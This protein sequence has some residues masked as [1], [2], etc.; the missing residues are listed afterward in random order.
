PTLV[1]KPQG[2][3]EGFIWKQVS[4][5]WFHSAAIGSDGNL[6]TWGWNANGK[7]GDGTTTDRHTPTL[8]EK[9]TGAP[10]G[11][12][13]KQVILGD[14]HTAA[15]G[16][17]GN[18]YIWGF[19]GNSRL[20]DGTTTDRHTPT[21]V[22]KPQGTPDGFT[23]KQISLGGWH[24]AAIGSDGNLY[25]W[26]YSGD[27]ELGRDISASIPGRPGKID[28][29]TGAPDGF[30]W[31]QASLGIWDSA[32]FGSDGNLY[33]W[34]YNSNG[35]L[36]DGT[37]TNM[38]KPTLVEKPTGAPAGFTW[39][40]ASLGFYHS[41]AIGSDGQLYTWGT[42]KYGQL[43][44]NAT[45]D[46]NRPGVVGFPGAATPTSVLFGQAKTTGI[47][48]GPD[49][50]WQAT[51]PGHDPGTVDV[52]VSW[53]R[54]GPQPDAHLQYTFTAPG[55]QVG[56]ASANGSCPAP[57]G[58]P[59][60][61]TVVQG[62][63]AER[64]YPDPKAD[65]CLFDGW[66]QGDVAYDFSQPVTH[67][68]TLTAHWTSKD[69]QHW[70]I[71]PSHGPA[72]GGT[73]TTLTPPK[74]RGIRFSQV[75]AGRG[76]VL[77]VGSDGN[78]YAW[79]WNQYGQLGDGTATDR[80]EPVR[81]DKPEGAPQGFTWV[82]ASAG[83]AFSLGLGS[84]GNIYSWGDNESATLGRDIGGK[85]INSTPADGRPGK[86]DK[87]AGAPK[88][89]TWKHAA[90]GSLHALGLGSDG[91]L[92]SW[93]SNEHHQLG[94]G[95]ATDRSTPTLVAKPQGAPDGF[96]WK[97]MSGWGWH[98]L[99]LGSD[100]QLY[101]W[102]TDTRGEVGD[103]ILPPT[104]PDR[105]TPVPVTNP[106]GVSS[107]GQSQMGDYY[108]LAIGSD[109]NAYG[110]GYGGSGNIGNGATADVY[111]P[112]LTSKPDGT[113]PGF[114]WKQVSNLAH[115]SLGIGSDGKTYAWGDN[116][117]GQIGDGTTTERHTPVQVAA[118]ADGPAGLT[119]VQVSAGWDGQ[120][121]GLASDGYLYSWGRNNSGM[122]GDGGTADRHAPGRVSMPG[123][124]TPTKVLF[125]Q[126]R[127]TGGIAASPDGAWRTATPGHEPGAVDVTV[128][129]DR[130]GPQ[131]DAHLEYTYD[132]PDRTVS[133]MDG[134]S[135]F[136]RQTV[137]DGG[138]ASRPAADPA[139]DGCLFDGWF[140]G[141]VAYDFT[142]PVTHDTTLTARWTSKD[143]Q[144]WS[145]SPAQ[146]PE[147]G[148]AEVTLTPPAPRGVRLSRA[149]L[150][151][152]HAAAIGSDGNLYAWGS[153]GSGQLGDGT[154][155]SRDRPVMVQKPQGAPQGFTWKQ[156]SL[157]NAFTAAIGSDG[158]LYAWGL[159][160][161]GQLGDGTTTSR[162]TPTLVAK[163]QGA[164][165]G[166]AWKQASLGGA[167]AA[168]IG[169]D[170][171]LYAWGGNGNGQLGDGTA[172]SRTTP[173]L[174]AKPQ[175]APAGFAWKQ[176]SL[177]NGHSAAIGSD[178]QL[179]AWGGNY[180]GQLGDGTA[181]SRSTP[182]MVGKPQGAPQGFAWK[183]ASL[184]NAFTAAI[185]SDGN[186]Y[187]WGL[188]S[189][190]QLGDGT[191]T[192]RSTPAPA[193]KPQGAA[194]GFAWQQASL[195]C[196]HAAAIGTDGQLYTWGSNSS[197]QLGDGTTTSRSTPAPAGKP[198]GAPQGFAWQQ[199]S[200]G[201]GATAAI[202]T[203]GNLHT[204]GSNSSGQL[205]R[206]P[207]ETRPA[208]RPGPAGF[209][210]NPQATRAAFDGKPG[211]SLKPDPDGTWKVAT[212]P[213]TPGLATV[214]IDWT[215]DGKQQQTDTSNT[216]RYLP[217][218]S[219]PLTGGDGM[220]LLLATGLLAA[221]AATAAKNH[222]QQQTRTAA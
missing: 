85:T 167:H 95:T 146:G 44:D 155:T 121:Y 102:G 29:P 104:H 135:A 96:A 154:T 51:T 36:G 67:D 13:W 214:A 99:A 80:H 218:A 48:A 123:A 184:G 61:Q 175:G 128:V 60:S 187:A 168:A 151:Y 73:K 216:Y 143:T 156:A 147:S 72:A 58:M 133:F 112:T 201:D 177:G 100:N 176:A 126:A 93:G 81:V 45:A 28:K 114:I 94:D 111:V 159:N 192:S 103:G 32:A 101:G 195:G 50:T 157:G 172:T 34:G 194:K 7:L 84:D 207:A 105:E 165:Q 124:A 149:S 122:L 30:T 196:N 106:Q 5:G 37:A 9:P 41:A 87:P 152:S 171:Q 158:N 38:N 117:Y 185:G 52:T 12:T 97:Q 43:G 19:N 138:Q 88:G 22:G 18:L 27:G 136:L 24:S 221:G 119:W 190:G 209:P 205:G 15:F 39:K 89:F 199:A 62:G 6:Y 1:G 25:T 63:Q 186:L 130:N 115:T 91:Q 49:G 76:H 181:T 142:R 70:S 222:R 203:D 219:L 180:Y 69:T 23:W 161:S 86:I 213:Y 92:Y 66:F 56:F 11:F 129:W 166:F 170:G 162:S 148:G 188:N 47:T 118:P 4:L 200:L 178:G 193:G 113:R 204:W 35:Q 20:G 110:W 59:A 57:T 116:A 77:A 210:G 206:S 137:P 144:H 3:P 164:A 208:S 212:P 46:R 83:Y 17:D 10:A 197:G 14:Q 53:N 75:S 217:I 211:T 21:L 189:S 139:R 134:G 64:P 54:N 31:Q 153:N 160:S 198:Q 127:A 82:Q 179:Y 78:L 145:I 55:H 169:T 150:G 174:V 132:P 173:T 109:G 90:A 141:D 183:Q 65:G 2:T 26:G 182:V 74:P 8:V 16:S 33:T 40:Q 107:W 215:Q 202:G 71:S 191:T 79:G 120:S 42:N 98:S 125:G 220:L 108:S 68:T 140:Q 131:P 163:P